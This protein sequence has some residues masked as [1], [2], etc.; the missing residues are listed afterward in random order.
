MG[1][2][3]NKRD[4]RSGG[5]AVGNFTQDDERHNSGSNGLNDCIFC[6]V[7]IR[8]VSKFT[9]LAGRNKQDGLGTAIRR[10]TAERHDILSTPY[11]ECCDGSAAVEFGA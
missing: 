5:G 1:H 2:A 6:V 7:W 11:S 9:W 3:Y 4:N 10:C 8:I